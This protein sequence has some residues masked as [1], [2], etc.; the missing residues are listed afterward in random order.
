MIKNI[1]GNFKSSFKYKQSEILCSFCP[2]DLTQEHL[3]ICPKRSKFRE[4][5]NLNNLDDIIIYIRRTLE[6][7][8]DGCK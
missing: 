7:D 4:D 1:P 3:L 8:M 5:L 6:G 2:V